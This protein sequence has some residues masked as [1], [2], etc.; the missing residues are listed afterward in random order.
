MASSERTL[1]IAGVRVR[2]PHVPYRAQSALMHAVVTAVR[3]REHALVESPTGTGKTLALLCAAL[4][5]QR[6]TRE[7]SED[8]A[9][10]AREE[11]G[12]APQGRAEAEEVAPPVREEGGEEGGEE[13]E[14]EKEEE[15][16]S[17]D[18]DFA[19]PT[20]FR[21][22]SWQRG[23]AGR[24][25]KRMEADHE[26][27]RPA[28][29]FMFARLL[30]ME[31]DRPLDDGCTQ[32]PVTQPE[33]QDPSQPEGKKV[34][35]I[36]YATRTHKQ[37]A[38][39]ISE[40]RKTPYRPRI[41]VLAS[42][43]EYCIR[44]DVRSAV[45]RD[46]TC[47]AL[48]KAGDCRHY[49]SAAELAAHE[50]LKGEAWDIEELTEL[51]R[52]HG[53][54][55]YYASHELYQKAEI[56]FCP[57]SFLVD[58]IVRGARGINLAGDVV[59]LDEAHNIENYARES[60][61]FEA[62]IADVRR[63]HD[64]VDIM[65]LTGCFSG[66]R[67]D[68]GVA[69]RRLKGP[70]EALMAIV[71]DAVA[72]NELKSVEREEMAVY[73]REELL[74][75]LSLAK[76]DEEQIKRWRA[77]YEFIVNY[78]DGNE[79][80]RMK[81]MGDVPC[82]SQATV[83]SAGAETVQRKGAENNQDK[84]KTA[85]SPT[86]MAD[87]DSMKNP[88]MT[89]P[90][91]PVPE[92]RPAGFGYG[93]DPNVEANELHIETPR[94][95]STRQMKRGKVGNKV[96]RRGRKRRGADVAE[97][98][99]W[100]AKCMSMTHS[101]LTTLE[102]LFAYPNDFALVVDRRTVDYITTMRVQVCCLNAAVCFRDISNKARAVI[103]TSGTLSPIDSFAG[104]LGTRFTISKSLPHV[105]DVRKQLFVSVVAEGPGRERFD[106]TYAGSSKFSFQDSLGE[107]LY[108]YCRV[109][110]SGVLV[111]FPSYRLMAQLHTRWKGSGAWDK[112]YTVKNTVLVEPH[113]RGEDFDEIV[114]RYQA[115]SESDG[116]AILF[117][118]CRGKLSEGVDFRDA[119]SRGVILVGIPFPYFGD[120]VVSR[121]RQWND[122]TRKNKT[123]SKLQSGTEW[124][125]MQAY[126]A[127][128]QAL[129]RAVRHR[130]D[131]GAVLL[132]DCRFRQKHVL[133]QLPKWTQAGIQQTDGSHG[134]LLRGLQ[135]FY[136]TVQEQIASS[137][138]N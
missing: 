103:V 106:A 68:L 52:K 75:K 24:G 131:Y 7:A 59:I 46:E 74:G 90:G 115:A 11:T 138:T 101:L 62:D 110:P 21:D 37:V 89:G 26:E 87:N 85:T 122:R 91:K 104:E 84:S 25:R 17:S 36:F 76:V 83:E 125:E 73:E 31:Q 98:R 18:S 19:K 57:Y 94:Q 66:A 2:F 44:E 113:R 136:D 48:V 33:S 105:I 79:A 126:R 123:E 29:A 119:T 71:D 111:F 23:L 70:L 15:G 55:P 107:A 92:S 1:H 108:D 30:A 8:R 34:P 118:V 43:R 135:R 22:V 47:K 45:A 130:Y 80:K 88:Q 114:G 78:G 100:I 129:G 12:A 38:N 40:L 50:E 81:K 13:G 72:S 86:G 41:T 9:E 20:K 60:A 134:A 127:L 51:G 61:G 96:R 56:V 93:C 27:E 82:D 5:V 6:H 65:I 137:V 16:E 32:G 39:V 63:A 4:A 120:V 49:Y 53:G 42:R 124:Y 3:T 99:P 116:G 132:L 97:Q 54:C 69:Y 35:R 64:E 117:G 133:K 121:K 58:P 102:Y 128:N 112:L 14:D 77:M 109:I 28:N 67:G 95:D 10:N